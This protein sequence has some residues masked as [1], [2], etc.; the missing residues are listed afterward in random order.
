[1][2]GGGANHAVDARRR[3]APDENS[4]PLLHV[5]GSA[6]DESRAWPSSVLPGPAQTAESGVSPRP[7]VSVNP[8]GEWGPCYRLPGGWVDEIDFIGYQTSRLRASR[9][10]VTGQVLQK[11][12][13]TDPNT[14]PAPGEFASMMS[15]R[16]GPAR[17]IKR[18]PISTKSRNVRECPLRR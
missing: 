9:P 10:G 18:C 8:T 13:V 11:T 6:A 12:T 3:T 16:P 1:A 15:R 5:H 4:Q 17:W 2:D 7:V 14:R